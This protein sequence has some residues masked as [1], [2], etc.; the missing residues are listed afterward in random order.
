MKSLLVL[1][2]GIGLGGALPLAEGQTT[3]SLS[4]T[5]VDPF[6]MQSSEMVS[7]TNV[8]FLTLKPNEIMKG[9]TMMSGIFVEAAKVKN[10]LQLI[11]PAA[12][13]EYGSPEDNIV[14]DPLNGRVTG[15]KLFSFS[16]K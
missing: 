2:V 16:F 10:P 13:T 8:L 9:K 5:H 7:H 3:N 4:A 12:P 6:H 14:R 11:S 1:L 15:L